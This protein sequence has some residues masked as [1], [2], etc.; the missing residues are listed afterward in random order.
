MDTRT[1]ARKLIRWAGIGIGALVVSAALGVFGL[2]LYGAHRLEKARSDFAAHWGHLVLDPTPTSLPDHLN[3]AR[4]L[5]AGGQAIICSIEDQKF[6]GTLS[7]ESARGWTDTEQAR[8]RWILHEQ[9][10][11]LGILLRSGSFPAFH[12]GR[13]GARA[14]YDEIDFLST[15]TGLR[16]LTVE[17]RLAWSEGRASDCLAALDAVSR[18]A[19]GLLR[20]PVVLTSTLGSAAARWSSS[21]A[22]DLVSDPCT[23][24]ATLVEIQHLLPSEDPIHSSNITLASSIAEI[25]DEGLDYVEDVHD[26]SMS[27]SLPAGVSNRYLLEDLVVAEI[28]ERWSRF[29]E[30]GQRPAADWPADAGRSS[31]GDAAW[32]QWIALTGAYTPN[33]LSARVRAQAASTDLQQLRAALDLRLASPEGLDENA[34]SL[35]EDTRPTVLTGQPMSCGYH[36]DRGTI[37]IEVPGAEQALSAFVSPGNHASRFP[38]IELPV[39]SDYCTKTMDSQGQ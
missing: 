38:P 20:T 21:A 8:A 16:L 17:A 22:A 36:E 39:G 25:T 31:W 24:V 29:L 35:V 6:I 3:G 9:Q 10:N 15:V 26:P 23:S 7:G 30:I 4:W 37:V 32:P 34:C 27:W 28:L 5:M 18:A 1:L 14:T 33:L 2:H 12:F 11:A 13:D 19:D